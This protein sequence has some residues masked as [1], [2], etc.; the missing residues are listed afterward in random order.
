MTSRI[1]AVLL[2]L[3]NPGSKYL[4]TRHNVGFLFLD[5]LVQEEG[6]SWDS[7]SAL[8]KKSK[9]QIAT[10]KV[11]GK[12]LLAVKPQ[13]FMNLSGESLEGLYTKDPKLAD[14]PLIVVQ[15]EVDIP[16]GQLRVKFGGGDAGHNGLKDLRRFLGHGEYHRLRLGVGR[17]T[18]S[19]SVADHVLQNFSKEEQKELHSLFDHTLHTLKA[20][21]AGN[22]NE[23]QTRAS[24][25]GV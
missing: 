24:R 20:V 7:S 2:G 10:V 6:A 9:A 23:A 11:D 1:D 3:G 13:T 21:L 18:G 12:T 17:S 25:A 5:V 14:L 4:M 22:L 8:A 19:L 16:F 15:D